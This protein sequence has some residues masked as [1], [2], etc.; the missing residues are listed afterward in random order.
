[1]RHQVWRLW[2]DLP[3]EWGGFVEGEPQGCQSVWYLYV[4]V[5]YMIVLGQYD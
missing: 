4:A 1:V 3:V 2:N 5:G